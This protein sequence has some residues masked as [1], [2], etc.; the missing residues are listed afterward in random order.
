MDGAAP[1]LVTAMAEA[2][3]AVSIDSSGDSPERSPATKYPVKVSPVLYAYF[4][5][6]F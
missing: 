1:F 3:A 5:Y 6:P 4:K 2:L